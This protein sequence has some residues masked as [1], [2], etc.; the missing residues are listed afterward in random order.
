M[1]ARRIPVAV[2][3][4]VPLFLFLSAE[5]AGG[6][7]AA[8]DF[9]GKVVNFLVLFGGLAL[10][11]RKPLAGLLARRAADAAE[12]LRRAQAAK[13][14]ALAKLEESQA[15]TAGLEEEIRRMIQHAK[16]VA[17]RE[18]E[19]IDRQAD[20]EA[21]R[22]RRFAEQEVEQVLRA[23]LLELRGYA[24]ERA[25]S[26]ARERI[27]RK[28]GPGDQA[29]LIDKPIERLAERREKPGSGS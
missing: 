14:D 18:G 10:L 20:E 24:A 11:L 16:S 8:L 23:G 25:T 7:S 29:A 22:I 13:R 3:L 15:K 4:V 19:R 21:R 2:L 27:L 28:L 6:P 5:E 1:T 17:A 12:S 26:L 9:A